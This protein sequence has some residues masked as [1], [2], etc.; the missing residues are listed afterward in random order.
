M[1]QKVLGPQ[2]FRQ[3]ADECRYLAQIATNQSLKGQALGVHP[4]SETR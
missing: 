1:Q 2:K 4:E 3:L